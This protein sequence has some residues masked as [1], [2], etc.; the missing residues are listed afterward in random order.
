MA[1]STGV[2]KT[3]LTDH[4]GLISIAFVFFSPD[5]E[6][7]ISTGWKDIRNGRHEIQIELEE[8]DHCK[9]Y[10][11]A[12]KK[13]DHEKEDDDEIRLVDVPRSGPE[14]DDKAS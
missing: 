4:T 8:K 7:S 1:V 9:K 12:E 14:K 3:A 2:E 11:D 6:Q 13:I 10:T 5:A